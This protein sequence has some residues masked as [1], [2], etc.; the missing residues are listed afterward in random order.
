MQLE[1]SLRQYFDNTRL[2]AELCERGGWPDTRELVLDLE[3][4]EER[5]GHLDVDCQVRFEEILMLGCGGVG[6]RIPREG[7]FHLRLDA[8]DGRVEDAWLR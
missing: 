7:R 2:I 4:V 3:R 8:R 6:K 1:Q 5:E